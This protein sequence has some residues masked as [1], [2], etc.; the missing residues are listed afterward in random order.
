[1][2]SKLATLA[3]A[4]ALASFVPL[5]AAHGT[6]KAVIIDGTRYPGPLPFPDEPGTS[7]AIRQVNSV[8]PVK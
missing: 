2:F 6:L 8:D 3:L 5:A 4:L 7:F 1:M